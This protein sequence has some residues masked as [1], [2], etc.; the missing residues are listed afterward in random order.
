MKYNLFLG[1]FFLL[2]LTVIEMVRAQAPVKYVQGSSASFLFNQATPLLVDSVK[3]GTIKKIYVYEVKYRSTGSR[4]IDRQFKNTVRPSYVLTAT[5]GFSWSG[6][7]LLINFPAMRPDLDFDV[8]IAANFS[9]DHLK[10]ALK[11]NKDLY[12]H[13]TDPDVVV[14]AD[15]KLASQFT[16]LY[17]AVNQVPANSPFPI[18]V[19]D[20]D[21]VKYRN[22]IYKPLEATYDQIINNNALL[23][24]PAAPILQAEINALYRH[25]TQLILLQYHVTALQNIV[26]NGTLAKIFNGTYVIT[27]RLPAAETDAFDLDKRISNLDTSKTIIRGLQDCIELVKVSAPG[28]YARLKTELPD[29]SAKLDSNRTF[30][31]GLRDHINQAVLAQSQESMWLAQ[32]TSTSDLKT[33]GI[34]HLTLDVGMADLMAF[35][36]SN[37][38]TQIPKLFFGLNYYFISVDKTVN[39]DKIPDPITPDNTMSHYLESRY[40]VWQRLSLTGGFMLGAYKNKDFDNVYSNFSFT[41]GP[42]Y[43]FGKIFKISVGGAL[44]KRFNNE[45]IRT[46]STLVLGDYVSLSLDYDLLTP[47]TKVTDMIFK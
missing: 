43:R 37:K 1:I 22:N 32:G 7:S 45:P 16:T 46:Y 47:I 4:L 35:D 12:G 10:Q 13:K 44:L 31:Q 19:F 42:S 5:K 30:I 6:R 8:L 33:T 41:L 15:P 28:I 29:W 11:I 25:I 27:Y 39:W 38:F 20:Y 21:L 26:L 3:M 2:T 23:K 36:N 18:S 17:D 14:A 9:K 34:R 40:S 24:I